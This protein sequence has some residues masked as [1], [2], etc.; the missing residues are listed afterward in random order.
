MLLSRLFSQNLGSLGILGLTGAVRSSEA[1]LGSP[2]KH[3]YLLVMGPSWWVPSL[4]SVSVS[5]KSGSWLPHGA[6][7]ISCVFRKVGGYEFGLWQQRKLG[8]NLVSPS[9]SLGSCLHLLS[10]YFLICKMGLTAEA[11]LIGLL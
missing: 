9:V 1:L 7:M 10:L 8:L 6:V 11:I 3:S 5:V 2:P 4:C